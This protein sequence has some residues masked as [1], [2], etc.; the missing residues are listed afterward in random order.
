MMKSNGIKNLKVL[1][2]SLCLSAVLLTGCGETRIPVENSDVV[3]EEGK[4]TGTISYEDTDQYVK[5]VTFEKD[6][7]ESNYL[8][9]KTH[10]EISLPP[11]NSYKADSYYDLKTGTCVIRYYNYYNQQKIVYEIGEDL[12]IVEEKSISPYLL[13]EDFMKKDYT[14]EEL[15]KFFKE[16]VL[17]TLS[18]NNKEM[19][20]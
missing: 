7:K 16:K 11:A 18:S 6:G 5:I 12:N 1:G 3:V 20:K 14:V 13:S 9:I 15:L 19:V 4:T 10:S 8:M 17:P 2:A